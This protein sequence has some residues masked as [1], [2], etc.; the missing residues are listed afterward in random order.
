MEELLRKPLAER[1]DER[2]KKELVVI[3]VTQAAEF[4]MK[5]PDSDGS[6]DWP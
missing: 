6:L 3:N 1:A 4:T 2:M 5:R